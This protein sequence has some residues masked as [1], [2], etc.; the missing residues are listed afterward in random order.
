MTVIIPTALA[1][2]AIVYTGGLVISLGAYRIMCQI[3]PDFRAWGWV[4]PLWP[5]VPL[6]CILMAWRNRS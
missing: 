4:V 6:W 5:V 1:W 3:Y 2:V